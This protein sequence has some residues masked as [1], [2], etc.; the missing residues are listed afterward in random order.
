MNI[1][2]KAGNN[3]KNSY[4]L[5]RWKLPNTSYNTAYVPANAEPHI[6]IQGINIADVGT[7]LFEEVR[8]SYKQDKNCHILNSLI[9]KAC[10]YTAL[11]NYLDDIWKI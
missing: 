2:H 11:E 8:E 3:N 10:K 4:G 1:V 9:E 6:P 5:S 7:E